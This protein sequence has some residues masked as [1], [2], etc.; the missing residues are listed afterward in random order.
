M[1][2]KLGE[3]VLLMVKI[4]DV[5]FWNLVYFGDSIVIEVKKKD[6][7]VGFMM[8]SGVIKK[9]DGMCVFSVDFMV[10]W[11]MFEGGVLVVLVV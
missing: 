5:C 2:V 1:G 3:G 8:M 11:K 7:V 9:V 4:S 6:M 10:V